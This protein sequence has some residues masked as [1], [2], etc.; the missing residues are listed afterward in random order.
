MPLGEKDIWKKRDYIN[1]IRGCFIPRLAFR[2]AGSFAC[3]LQGAD[4]IDH[5]AFGLSHDDAFRKKYDDQHL[6]FN[7]GNNGMWSVAFDGSHY[8]LFECGHMYSPTEADS[9]RAAAEMMKE[10]GEIALKSPFSIGWTIM[11]NDAVN[12]LGPLVGNVQKWQRRIKKA[13]DPNTTAD[14]M[15][16]VLPEEVTG[17]KGASFG[18]IF[19]SL[20]SEADDAGKREK[21]S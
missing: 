4:T 15:G 9:W 20:P 17:E 5:A 10:G 12:N 11:G 19:P 2:A 7:D 13:L 16:Y 21:K 18:S 3:P 8:A 14:P 6:L 1:M